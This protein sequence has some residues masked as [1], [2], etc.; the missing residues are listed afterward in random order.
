MNALPVGP[1]QVTDADLRNRYFDDLERWGF[2]IAY[3]AYHAFKYDDVTGRLRDSYVEFASEA[4]RRGFSACIQIDV[5]MCFGDTVGVEEAQYDASNQPVKWGDNGF[6]ASFSSD[7]WKNHLKDLTAVFVKEFGYDYVVFGEAIYNVDIPGT[8]DRFYDKYLAKNTDANY[9]NEPKETPEYLK[10]QAAKANSVEEFYNELSMNAKSAGAKKVGIIL[11][12]FIPLAA[13]NQKNK[14]SEF[15]NISQIAYSSNVDF[16][17]SGLKP[18]DVHSGS[19]QTGDELS[20]S[21]ELFYIEITAQSFGK[22][23]VAT[24]DHLVKQSDSSIP[25]LLPFNFYRDTILAAIAGAPCGFNF[26][27]LAS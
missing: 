18:A 10:V 6:Y 1:E 27:R 26:N 25:R 24:S 8:K 14:P 22:D 21:P 7:I 23:L 4:H 12:P 3:N 16:V 19:V 11:R 9:P 5:S 17:V 2:N 20:N 15:L 13:D